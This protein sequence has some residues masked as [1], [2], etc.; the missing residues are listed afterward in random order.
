MNAGFFDYNTTIQVRGFS[1]DG[2]TVDG[3]CCVVNCTNGRTVPFTQG[4]MY[5]FHTGGLNTLRCDGSV[6]FLNESVAPAVLGAMI[7]RTGGEVTSN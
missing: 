3:G 5:G 2:V 6:Q 4:Q 7:T 1:N